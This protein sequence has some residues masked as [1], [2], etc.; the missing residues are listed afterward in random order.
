MKC[1][2]AL[3][4]LVLAPTAG[5]AEI[6][7]LAVPADQGMKFYW[8]PK[9]P[10][11][12]GWEHDE[13]V[14]RSNGVNML[15]PVGGTFLKAP[16][17]IYARAMFKPRVPET[18]SL[19]Q[20]ISDDKATFAKE[21]P[22]IVVVELDPIADGDGKAHRLFS[23]SPSK[24]GSWE[25]VAYGEEGEFYLIF[26]VSGNSKEALEQATPDFRKV[27]TQYRERL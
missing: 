7:K 8:W 2:L 23:Y 24:K 15:V 12:P 27:L 14:S 20:L 17:V 26:T 13:D 3:L 25:L 1:L 18:K 22:G 6:F 9:L 10:A 4:A 16:A 11:I 19:T 21:F 5:V